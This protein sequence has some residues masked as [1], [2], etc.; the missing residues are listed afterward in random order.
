MSSGSLPIMWS[1]RTGI[2]IL[3]V[4]SNC[5]IVSSWVFSMCMVISGSCGNINAACWGH[6]KFTSFIFSPVPAWQT[7]SQ[8]KA[9]SWKG[10]RKKCSLMCWFYRELLPVPEPVMSLLMRITIKLPPSLR[11]LSL[12]LWH[13]TSLTWSS[14]CTRNGRGTS[15]GSLSSRL[16]E[17][18]RAKLTG[19]P[20]RFASSCVQRLLVPEQLPWI[21][22]T[23]CMP[24]FCFCYWCLA[25]CCLN[26]FVLISWCPNSMLK[27]DWMCYHT[28]SSFIQCCLHTRCA[29]LVFP[30]YSLTCC[31]L[32]S[33]SAV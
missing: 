20:T 7:S 29:C 22:C 4:G 18:Q 21:S 27:H 10:V 6:K 32:P 15:W 16:T 26:A 24:V 13:F 8:R 33:A 19:W 5:Y 9:S 11:H 14:R 1:S 23:V 31:L 3:Y 2:M 12:P 17:R 25:T 28:R 30:V